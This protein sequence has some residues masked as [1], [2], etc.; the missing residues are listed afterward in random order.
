MVD[1]RNVKQ[2]GRRVFNRCGF[3]YAACSYIG[4]DEEE[5]YLSVH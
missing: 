3:L 1:W 2:P 5:G 4:F